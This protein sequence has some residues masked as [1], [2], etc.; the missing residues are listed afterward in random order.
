MGDAGDDAA[1]E[2]VG[3]GATEDENDTDSLLAPAWTLSLPRL[4]AFAGRSG[5]TPLWLLYEPSLL[6]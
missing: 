5:T 1:D 4:L 6:M 3:E 2:V